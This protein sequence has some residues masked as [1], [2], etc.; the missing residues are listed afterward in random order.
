[1]LYKKKWTLRHFGKIEQDKMSEKIGIS[2]EISQILKNRDIITE[3]DAEIFMN[4]S[5]DY[6]RDPFLMKDMQKGVDRIK[7]AIEKNERIFIFGDYDVDGV[8]STSVL[9][10][11]FKSIGYDVNYY[12]PNRLEE[13]Y[14]ISIEA[15]EKINEIGCDLLISVDCGITSAKEVEFAKTLGMDVII[16]DHHECQDEIP[17][18]IAVINP[19]QEDCTY[20]YDFLCG[21]GVAFKLIQALTPSEEFKTTMYDYLEIVTLATICDIVPLKDENRIIVKN[22]LNM[23]KDGRNIGLKELI[24]VCGID[25]HQI[26]SSHIGYSVGPRINASGRLGYSYLGVELFTADNPEKAKE[27]ALDLEEKNSERQLIES[28]MY[29]EAEEIINSDASYQDDKVLVIAKEGWQHGIIG[30]VA[31]KLTEKYYKPTILLTIED[32]M[33]TGSARSIKGFSIFDALV[34]CKDLMT[35]FGGHEQAAGLSMNSE[36]VEELRRRV[37]EIADYNL[38]QEDMIENVKVEYELQEGQVSLDL[39][40]DLH[41]LEPFG[42][43]NP[44]P[45]FIMRDLVLANIG[46]VGASKQH[47]KLTLQKDHIYEAIGFNM[48]YLAD[49]F[50]RGDKVDVLF[51]LDEN[52]YNNNRKVQ[53]LLKDIRM[54]HP[55]SAIKDFT[56]IKLFSK[57]VPEDVN[58]LY[59]INYNLENKRIKQDDLGKNEI[60]N[61]FYDKNNINIF[62]FFKEDT[63]V[64]CNTLNGFFRAYSDLSLIEDEFDVEFGKISKN[65]P[66]IK[67][68]FSPNLDKLELNIYNSIIL[69]DVLYNKEEYSYLLENIKANANFVK[70]YD[71]KSQLYLN[72]IVENIVPIR[73]EFIF[74][75]KYCITNKHIDI[76]LNKIK[77]IFGVMPLKLFVI[78]SVF[79][80]FNL[81][82]YKINENNNTLIIDFTEE[83]VSK[84]N[85]DESLILTNIRH[86]RES[87]LES[88]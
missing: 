70:Y 36:N 69:Y 22:G 52:N 68:I 1:M 15:L 10:L 61:N 5:L 32:K 37:N 9:V 85:L 49:D 77:A 75:Y 11:Y 47:L 19:K 34:K 40:D 57:I 63:L 82:N 25:T 59:K 43:N 13:G 71:E 86:L 80:E 7:Q 55:K 64:I 46:F 27:I 50:T 78:L 79:R 76:T 20:P 81:L 35:K 67:L 33:A 3:K 12:I 24:K 58:N 73:Q 53:F 31:S 60:S 2:P 14:G 42:M 29:S 28:K 16:T 66:K 17:D 72:N 84:F 38:T 56:S 83:S 65:Q 87:Y 26:K 18:A 88:Y 48:A 51:Q 8:S 54:A 74:V 6:L 41:M 45:R 23:M 44:T 4:P 62:E 30:I 39:V 21:C